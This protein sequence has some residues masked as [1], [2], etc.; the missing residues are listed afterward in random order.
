M[1]GH[2][3]FFVF[4]ALPFLAGVALGHWGLPCG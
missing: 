1:Y 3:R 4:T 2:I